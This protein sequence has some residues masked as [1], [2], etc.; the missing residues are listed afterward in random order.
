MNK[1]KLKNIRSK[2]SAQKRNIGSLPTN[3][4]QIGKTIEKKLTAS[5]KIWSNVGVAFF[6]Q[7]SLE[8]ISHFSSYLLGILMLVLTDIV[9]IF[10]TDKESLAIEALMTNFF[11]VLVGLL[12]INGL[13]YLAMRLLGSKARFKVFFSTVNTALFMSLLVFAIPV[14]LISF[15]LFSTMLRSQSA[16]NLF[17]S[18]IPFYNYLI[19]GWSSETLAK[20]KGMKSIA[21]ALI[22]LL[23]IL[24]FNLLLQ[25]LLV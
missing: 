1:I 23:L 12:V 7:R 8:N 16:I 22:A 19:Y 6:G 18:I 24:F 21:V 17:F 10:P 3:G 9:L 14:A 4:E 11:V 20:L 25:L 13:T 5:Q 2:V 15:A